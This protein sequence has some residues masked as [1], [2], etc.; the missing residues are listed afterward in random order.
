MT[1]RQT[2]K[3]KKKR[4]ERKKDEK[5]KKKEERRNISILGLLFPRSGEIS[6]ESSP[7]RDTRP[8]ADAL[9]MDQRIKK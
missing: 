6:V 7:F 1:L 2:K 4:K 8:I 3:K 5:R 9:K